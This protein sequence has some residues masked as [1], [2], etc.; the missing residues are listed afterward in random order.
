[1]LTDFDG[2]I[3]GKSGSETVFTSFY[4]S[5]LGEGKRADYYSR[6]FKS[7]QEVQKLFEEKFGKFDSNFDYSQ[8]DAGILMSKEAVSFFKEALHNHDHSILIIT[9]NRKDYIQALFRFHGF[10]EDEIN[11]LTINDSGLKYEAAMNHL[12]SVEYRQNRPDYI[13]ILDDNRED[14][15]EMV[16]AVEIWSKLHS[17]QIK[18][19]NES[20]GQFKWAQ[21][22]QDIQTLTPIQNQLNT[23]SPEGNTPDCGTPP[24]D[25]STPT[26]ER[27]SDSDEEDY[28]VHSEKLRAAMEKLVD[29]KDTSLEDSAQKAIGNSYKELHTLLGTSEEQLSSSSDNEVVVEHFPSILRRSMPR[30]NTKPKEDDSNLDKGVT[31]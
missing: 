30:T 26:D 19:Y 10:T 28:T 16:R 27:P 12:T 6:S 29:N 8:K 2:T 7:A 17:E 18:Q 5:L 22:Q 4:Q 13:Y 24:S 14:Y 3:T 21:Y 23:T 25:C 1:M 9:K 15:Q 20:P 31:L 11:K